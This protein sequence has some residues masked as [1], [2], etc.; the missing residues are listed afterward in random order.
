VG[1]GGGGANAP[2][3]FFSEYRFFATEFEEEQIKNIFFL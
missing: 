3:V 1:C 2:R